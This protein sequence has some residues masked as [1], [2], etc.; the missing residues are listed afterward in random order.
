M[1]SIK[2]NP[3]TQRLPDFRNLGVMLRLL[4]GVN[5]LAL[6]A[7]LEDKEIIRKMLLRK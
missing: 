7:A 6:A 4:I 2:Q 1:P 3:A 5:L